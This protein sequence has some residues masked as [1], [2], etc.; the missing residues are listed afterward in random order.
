MNN[1]NDVQPNEI[2]QSTLISEISKINQQKSINWISLYN[3]LIKCGVVKRRFG[4]LSSNNLQKS[5]TISKKRKHSQ[6]N[7]CFNEYSTDYSKTFKLFLKKKD[8]SV[9]SGTV[10][11][12]SIFKL[13]K[14]QKFNIPKLNIPK[15]NKKNTKV[16]IKKITLNT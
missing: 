15:L 1:S 9:L 5:P 14:K 4:S 7:I 11:E 16:Y 10:W 3:D 8:W 2:Y 13:W 6:I 12:E